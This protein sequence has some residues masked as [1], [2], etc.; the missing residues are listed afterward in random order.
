M[1]AVLLDN[2]SP[3]RVSMGLP[4]FRQVSMEEYPEAIFLR[5][6]DLK[7]IDLPK[8]LLAIGRA[9]AGVDNIPV[10]FCSQRGIVVFNAPGANA[11]SVK[12]LV[13][14]MM[15][16]AV[17]NISPSTNFSSGLVREHLKNV[18]CRGV[19]PRLVPGLI[20]KDI[21]KMK[22]EFK[23]EE[24]AGKS[25]LIIGLGAIGSSLAKSCIA[26]G[27][28]VYGFDPY[29][30]S[31]KFAGITKVGSLD[32]L[33][34]CDFVSIHAASTDETKGMVN[35][36]FLDQLDGAILLNFSRGDLIDAKAVAK[37]LVD[38]HLR[39]YI[40]DFVNMELS[41]DFPQ[42]TIFTPHLGA[43]TKEAEER[44]VK[45]V[46]GQM[47]AFMET[48]RIQNSVNFPNCEL[49]PR[50]HCRLVISRFDNSEEM[51]WLSALLMEYGYNALQTVSKSRGRVSYSIMD[52]KNPDERIQDM[53]ERLAA[54]NQITRVRLI[55][56][57]A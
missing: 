28:S 16:N 5:S 24:I 43:S 21:E 12:E 26:L 47:Y 44:S 2:I 13:L 35:D 57:P 53:I 3:D 48:G 22:K 32:N 20:K 18:A 33:P 4:S 6:T 19:D 8:S 46:V 29:A 56:T 10:D 9:G 30:L 39:L 45:M 51:A 11:N 41:R 15:L 7:N 49:L 40:S 14:G 25:V 54:R 27:M 17:R 37:A 50:T 52:I 55:Q 34:K 23:G 31:E 36:K 38:G 1:R 42:K